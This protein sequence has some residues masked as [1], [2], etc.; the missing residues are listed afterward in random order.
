MT[1]D[2]NIQQLYDRFKV[3]HLKGNSKRDIT[4]MKDED[5]TA[6]AAAVPHIT[7]QE[8]NSCRRDINV[9]DIPQSSGGPRRRVYALLKNLRVPAN[10][11]EVAR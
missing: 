7:A 1:D 8:K 3:V 6:Q 2:D 9:N 4:W 5:C 11:T 10:S